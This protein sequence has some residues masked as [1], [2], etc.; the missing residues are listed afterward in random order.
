MFVRTFNRQ[1]LKLI[2]RWL[3]VVL[4]AFQAQLALATCLSPVKNPALAYGMTQQVGESSPCK[5]MS[6]MDSSVCLAHCL[7]SYQITD[8]QHQLSDD[9]PASEHTAEL[10][11]IDRPA[12]TTVSAIT[13]A[14]PPPPLR[15]L[16]CCLRY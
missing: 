5:N 2:G 7:Q 10:P 16:F 1:N 13:V 12:I 4:I 3:V 6:A 11:V 8:K 14:T 15:I 9:L